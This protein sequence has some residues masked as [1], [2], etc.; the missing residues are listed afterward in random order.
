MTELADTPRRIIE[1]RAENFRRLSVV[2]I[3]P[4]TDVVQLTG[5]NA[6]GKTSV[7]DG[8]RGLFEGTR[9]LPMKPIRSG[10]ERG[11]LKADLGDIIVTRRFKAD[12]S[13]KGYTTDLIIESAEGARFSSPQAIL[14]ALVGDLAF[15]P[16]AF[17]RM[18]ADEQ[19]DAL[20]A[21]VPGVDFAADALADAK[22]FTART[23][24]NRAAK[25]LRTQA[26]AISLPPGKLPARVDVAALE[27]QLGDAAENAADIERR[28]GARAQAEERIRAIREQVRLL[29]EERETL[30]KRLDEAEPL[31]EV[32]DTSKLREDLAAGRAGNAIL[33][34]AAQRTELERQAAEKEAESDRLTKAMNDREEARQKAV[35]A[36]KMPVAGLGFGVGHILLNGEPFSQAS[37][38]EQLRTSLAIAA[39]MNPRLRVARVRDGNH[40]DEDAMAELERFA[41][42]ADLQIWI[43]RVDSSG[44]VGFVLEDGHLKGEAPP[45]G[46]A[47][48]EEAI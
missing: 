42:E 48:P 44:T 47:T 26:E 9:A 30:Q 22:D 24:I 17:T 23:D 2:A 5:K 11:I 3:R 13:P 38:A 7:L 15:D 43:E 29:E 39:A 36:A 21:F 14:D 18:S 12:D 37:D 41:A 46:D 28:R 20:K 35:S 4:D 10:C 34:R 8:L 1:F 19:F 40:L 45:E 6:Q 16:L 25:N 33:D 27:A 32:V 31:P